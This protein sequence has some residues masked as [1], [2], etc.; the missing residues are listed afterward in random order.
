MNLKAKPVKS[1]QLSIFKG[2]IK[3]ALIA[4]FTTSSQVSFN[5]GKAQNVEAPIYTQAFEA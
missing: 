2:K 1:L 3:I 4:Q 5:R